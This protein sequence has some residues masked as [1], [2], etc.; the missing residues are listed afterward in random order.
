MPRTSVITAID[1][2]TDKCVTLIATVQEE[3]GTLQVVG[4]SAVPSRGVKKSTI[5]NLEQVV[6]TITESLDGAERMA[7]FDVRSAYV[8]FSG[9]HIASQNSKGVVAVAS[10]SQ[11]ITQEDVERVIEAARAVSLPLIERLFM[12][13]LEI[14]KLIH[15]K[16]L[17]TQ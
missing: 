11:E 14:S 10:P 1:L 17:K 15:K 4:V 16:E 5:I 6:E 3:T 9:T 8:S 7:G 12:L 2:G 13:F